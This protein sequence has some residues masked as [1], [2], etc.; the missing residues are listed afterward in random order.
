[1][2]AD[3][4][5]T[6]FSTLVGQP[7]SKHHHLDYADFPFL[8]SYVNRFILLGIFTGLAFWRFPP[9]DIDMGWHLAG[10]AWTAINGAAPTLDPIGTFGDTWIDYHWLG[11]RI[12]YGLYEWG[13]YRAIAIF[14]GCIMALLLSATALIATHAAG[15]NSHPLVPLATFFISTT[16]ATTVFSSRPQMIALALVALALTLLMQKKGRLELAALTALTVISANIHVYWV[17]IPILF[18]MYRV[19]PRSYTLSRKRNVAGVILLAG[20]GAVSPY[21]W[22]NL[23]LLGEYASMDPRWKT[24]IVEFHSALSLNYQILAL[25]GF[26]ALLLLYK[27]KLRIL[28][29]FLLAVSSFAAALVAKKFLPL[30]GILGIPFFARR[31]AVLLRAHGIVDRSGGARRMAD[32]LTTAFIVIVMLTGILGFPRNEEA[33]TRELTTRYPIEP[34]RLVMKNPP[35]YSEGR[36]H[37]RILTHFNAGGWCA[38]GGYLGSGTFNL[39]VTSDGRTQYVPFSRYQAA[40]DALKAL[41]GWE[42]TLEDWKPDLVLAQADAPLIEELLSKGAWRKRYSDGSWVVLGLITSR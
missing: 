14:F 6:Q 21:G 4:P 15:K 23:W 17:I 5:T 25:L 19:I 8:P 11:Q 7:R 42:K 16:I 30:L 33:L 2:S 28:P 27:I 1:M 26:L 41:P 24:S 32:I 9:I 29:H 35:P 34:C 22:S 39:K 36:D 31:L 13:G 18:F 10:G 12:L 3:K 20:A 37:L 38:W 40:R